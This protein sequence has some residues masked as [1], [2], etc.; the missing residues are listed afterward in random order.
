MPL[1]I[2][3]IKKKI[4]EFNEH[5]EWLALDKLTGEIFRHR[6]G[7]DAYGIAKQILIIS[8]AWKGRVEAHEKQILE[9]S[10]D[11]WNEIT[12]NMIRI[13][14]PE[15]NEERI[16]EKIDILWK[17]LIFR[18][19]NGNCHVFFSKF[20]HWHTPNTFPIADSYSRNAL[21]NIGLEVNRQSSLNNYRKVIRAYSKLIETLKNRYPNISHQLTD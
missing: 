11:Y 3:E 19:I 9:N 2:R 8:R 13:P 15:N 5:P 4:E 1:D 16:I 12:Q 6:N 21:R 20:L 18:N 14:L 17:E 7:I 10:I